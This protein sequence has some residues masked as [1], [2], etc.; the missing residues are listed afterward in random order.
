MR[1]TARG[2]AV[3][4]LLTIIAVFEVT[5]ACGLD[6]IDSDTGRPVGEQSTYDGRQ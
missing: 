3:V 6:K 2:R 5:K 4:V 1:L